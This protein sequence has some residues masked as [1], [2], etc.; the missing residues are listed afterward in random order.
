MQPPSSG[1]RRRTP[2]NLSDDFYETTVAEKMKNSAIDQWLSSLPVRMTDPWRELGQVVAVHKR[3][4]DL[5]TDMTGQKKRALASKY[6]HF[7]RP[8][9][10]SIYDSRASGAIGKATPSI[11]K[12]ARLQTE[13]A[14]PK[15]LAFV[16]RS[17]WITDDVARRFKTPLT[18]RQV[19][20]I[21]GTRGAPLRPSR[22]CISCS[23]SLDTASAPFIT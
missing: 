16:R 20:K 14:D 19:D 11:R 18:P 22:D 3:L 12:I 4:M 23:S 2:S 5:F 10:F 8:D 6:L 9:L 17:Q 1:G 21:R 13:E 7:H 15:Y